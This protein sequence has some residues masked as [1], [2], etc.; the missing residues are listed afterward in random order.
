MTQPRRFG[1][2]S[3]PEALRDHAPLMRLA[4]DASVLAMLLMGGAD[5][6]PDHIEARLMTTWSD[7]CREKEQWPDGFMEAWLGARL[8]C[9]A[10][11]AFIELPVSDKAARR[12]LGHVLAG[13]SGLVLRRQRSLYAADTPQRWQDRKDMA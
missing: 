7:V 6:V 3:Y 8:L 5:E 1:P 9:S 11:L 4:V 2:N 13:A 12:D 10:M